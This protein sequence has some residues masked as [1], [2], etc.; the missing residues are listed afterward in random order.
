MVI[1]TTGVTMKVTLIS[2][3]RTPLWESLR[4]VVHAVVH[5]VI[6]CTIITTFHIHPS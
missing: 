3:P 4:A 1:K 6:A 2:R 5:V